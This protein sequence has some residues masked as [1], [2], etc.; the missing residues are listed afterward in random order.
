[1]DES[2]KVFIKLFKAGGGLALH[3]ILASSVVF[4]IFNPLYFNIHILKIK[5]FSYAMN[6]SYMTVCDTR[7]S[8]FKAE[9]FRCLSCLLLLCFRCWAWAF[10][11]FLTC[12]EIPQHKCLCHENLVM[13]GFIF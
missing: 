9:I 11:H 3:F 4:T 5:E 8:F 6:R 10:L 7:H 1:M 13:L 2:I 12:G